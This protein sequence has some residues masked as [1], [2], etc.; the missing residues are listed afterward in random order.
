MDAISTP[1]TRMR[2]RIDLVTMDHLPFKPFCNDRLAKSSAGAR[3]GSAVRKAMNLRDAD[4]QGFQEHEICG[5]SAG[6]GSSARASA[7]E[8]AEAGSDKRQVGRP[9]AALI[10]DPASANPCFR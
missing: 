4:G 8:A 6:P 10:P 1:T 2:P 5:D 3:P 9:D 7:P